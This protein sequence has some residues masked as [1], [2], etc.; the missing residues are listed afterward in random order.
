MPQLQRRQATPCKWNVNYPHIH[1]TWRTTHNH[2]IL[3]WEPQYQHQEH[4]RSVC[5]NSP[6]YECK[7]F[8]CRSFQN[9]HTEGQT[10][11]TKQYNHVRQIRELLVLRDLFNLKVHSK[12]STTKYKKISFQNRQIWKHQSLSTWLYIDCNSLVSLLGFLT[13]QHGCEAT[14][15]W[16][17]TVHTYIH[18]Y[19]IT[20][21]HKYRCRTIC[22]TV[23]RLTIL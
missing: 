6:L 15:S 23:Y 8:L 12:S 3:Y 4:Y 17:Y 21:P 13:I 11:K 16:N 22:T 9:Q 18:T 2:Q 5:S 14:S 10:P 1:H 19:F 20:V 7:G